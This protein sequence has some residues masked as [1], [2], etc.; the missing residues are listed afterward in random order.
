MSGTVVPHE[1]CTEHDQPLEWCRHD[2]CGAPSGNADVTGV[3]C[4]LP[5]GHRGD[6]ECMV[7]VTWP[8]EA[9]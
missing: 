7:L 8:D 4:E 9:P 6:H 1:Y 2:R 3:H 5:A